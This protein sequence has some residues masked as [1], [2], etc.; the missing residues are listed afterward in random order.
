MDESVKAELARA[1]IE[2]KVYQDTFEQLKKD[3]MDCWKRTG[4]DQ[5]KER[6]TI[7]FSISLLERIQTSLE[8]AMMAGQMA[9]FQDILKESQQAHWV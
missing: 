3:L 6:E 9:D 1:V 2:N 7:W 8:S 5:A 4:I